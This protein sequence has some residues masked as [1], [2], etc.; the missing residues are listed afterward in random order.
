MKLLQLKNLS[1]ILVILGNTSYSALAINPSYD[2]SETSF[3]VV[4]PVGGKCAEGDI[5]PPSCDRPTEKPSRCSCLRRLPS[6]T[7]CLPLQTKTT[8]SAVVVVRPHL[9]L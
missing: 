2:C 1:L 3:V 7:T 4:S 8:T 9:P 5:L 6:P